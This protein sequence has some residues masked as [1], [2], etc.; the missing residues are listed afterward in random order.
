MEINL[1][2]NQHKSGSLLQRIRW[3][4]SKR[5]SRLSDRTVLPGVD[6]LSL[7]VCVQDDVAVPTVELTV[8]LWVDGNSANALHPPDLKGGNKKHCFKGHKERFF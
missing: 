3:S 4:I 2:Y 5:K 7:P 8:A 1:R 6:D